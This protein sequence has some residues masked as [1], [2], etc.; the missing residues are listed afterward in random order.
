MG[1]YTALYTRDMLDAKDAGL[2]A[3]AYKVEE[4]PPCA[5]AKSAGLLLNNE[6]AAK[7]C[8]TYWE[9]VAAKEANGKSA[10]TAKGKNMRNK[11]RVRLEASDALSSELRLKIAEIAARSGY[12]L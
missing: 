8:E 2:I 12:E 10:P 3:D 7:R 4:T 6:R 5:V 1:W 11:G 9:R